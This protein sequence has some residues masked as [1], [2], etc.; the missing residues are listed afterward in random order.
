[1]SFF[2]MEP[3]GGYNVGGYNVGGMNVGGEYDDEYEDDYG[4]YAKG[5][6]M[7]AAQKKKMALGRARKAQWMSNATARL[8]SA[9]HPHKRA[10]QMAKESYA[11]MKYDMAPTKRRKAP[12]RSATVVRPKLKLLTTTALRNRIPSG[13]SL[14]ELRKISKALSS[15]GYGIYDLQTGG[16]IFDDIMHGVSQVADVGT[17]FLPFVM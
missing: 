3:M 13:I 5:Y 16:N 9:G 1:M 15:S 12:A 8:I 6:K 14:A 17:K 7:S 4:G 11:E 2:E 10:T